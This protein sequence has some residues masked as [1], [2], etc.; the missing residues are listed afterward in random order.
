MQRF[1]NVPVQGSNSTAM[2][3]AFLVLCVMILTRSIQIT[4]NRQKDSIP[5]LVV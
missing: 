4:I 2:V 3:V 1:S 5:L